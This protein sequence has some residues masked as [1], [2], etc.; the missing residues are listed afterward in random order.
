MYQDVRFIGRK[1]ISE[2]NFRKKVKKLS[3]LL[4]AG[5]CFSAL[6]SGCGK[7]NAETEE[8][9]KEVTEDVNKATTEEVTEEAKEE[10]T[11][12]VFSV[13]SSYEGIQEGWFAQVMKDRFNVKLDIVP[14]Y[15]GRFEAGM[16]AG[17]LGDIVVL[18]GDDYRAAK[19]KD[20]LLDWE[21]DDLL[22]R[23]GADLKKYAAAALEKD[24]TD[25]GKITGLRSCFAAAGSYEPLFYTWD[26]RWD[27]YLKLGHPE[28]RNKDDLIEVLKKMKEICPTDE[29]G[30]PTYA[31]SLFSEWDSEMVCPV[32]T[33]ASAYYGYDALGMGMYDPATGN[34]IGALDED[35][36]YLSMLYFFN[37]L[38]RNDL[39]DPDSA[40]ATYD[41][42][43]EKVKNGGVFLSVA[44]Y[45]GSKLYNTEGHIRD[46]K[47]MKSLIPEEASP[48]GYGISAYGDDYYYAIG[49]KSKHPELCMEILNYLATPEGRLTREYGPKGST[50]DYDEEGYITL[51]ELGR[52]ARE[53]MNTSMKAPYSGTF[54]DG[55]FQ[56]NCRTWDPDS[57]NPDSK[58]GETFN[59]GTWKC[60]IGEPVNEAD[61]DWQTYTGAATV[62]VY[63]AKKNIALAPYS[64]YEF[65]KPEG[66]LK[67]TW[68]QVAK[69]IRVSSWDAIYAGSD[70]EF[71]KMVDEMRAEAA[72]LGYQSCR[73]WSETE[74]ARRKAAEDEAA[75]LAEEH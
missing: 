54:A 47:L 20:L 75:K 64:E 27:L 2:M 74:A 58:V 3:V 32:W 45:A 67:E 33:A 51:T 15:A 59:A 31:V 57:V 48:I 28:V 1:E 17:D 69:W 62:N 50:W 8:A 5:V 22:G 4:L 18:V 60:T 63:A 7:E 68:D 65:A 19:Q 36:P 16:E 6:L 72:K 38:Y 35:S 55:L 11:L 73:D 13:R 24:R 66:D 41:T 53:D 34:F 56:I 10:V 46:N 37:Q 71:G 23:Y 30:K 14:T 43:S 9:T 39:L 12:T 29:A 49:S 44:D 26:I 42:M 70:E 61:K 25:G 52:N 40:A 21:K